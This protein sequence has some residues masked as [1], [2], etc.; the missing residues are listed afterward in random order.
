[1]APV[2]DERDDRDLRVTGELPSG[3]NGIFVR[4]GPN[5]QFPP[6]SVYHPFDGDGMIHAVY[7]EQGRARYRNRWV[8]SKGLLAERKRQRAC[9]GSVA[10]FMAPD[11][12]VLEEGGFLKNTANT[13][14]VRHAGR[15]FGLMEGGKP[16]E[17][18]REMA[19]L[20]EWDFAG[21]LKGPMT[22]HP[23]LDPVTGEMIFF[24]Y[25]PF[26]PYLRHH[27]VDAAGTLTHSIAIDIPA[28]VMVHDFAI[29]ERYS[30][31]FI[32]PG[33]FDVPA[34][35]RGEPGVRWE[36][37]RGTRIGVVPR[38]GRGDEVRWFDIPNRYVVHFWNAW[39]AGRT[40]VV[41]APAFESMPGG[42]A[43][44]DAPADI[45]TP[46][47][48][49]WTI[50]LDAGT[51]KTDQT[52][53]QPGE[54]PRI[55]DRFAGRP[56]RFLYNALARSWEFAFDFHGVIKYDVATGRSAQF[57][58]GATAVSGEHVFAPDPNGTA[59]DDGWLLTMVTDRATDTSSLAVLD[60]RDVAAG[61]IARIHIPR[62]V[63]LGFHANWFP[64][65]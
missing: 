1:M 14:T 4:N 12:D 42:L 26:P 54:F 41:H 32:A 36:P 59:E 11:P 5:P 18:S 3:L 28:P 6:V 63:P 39:E 65:A 29:T 58:H 62:R 7:L 23:K 8:E 33:I 45:Q 61:P 53:D 13:H 31:F 22:A 19:T 34:M 47:P 55:D 27:V 9:Y 57:I 25:S 17:L 20:G 24:A 15:Y 44:D 2:L 40:I 56:Q 50:D 60:A 46:V 30:I 37:E 21:A 64:E 43:F 38:H 10:K 51:V 35:M 49:K 52:D 16:T 48:W